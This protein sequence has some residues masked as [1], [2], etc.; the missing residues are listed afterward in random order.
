MEEYILSFDIP[1]DNIMFMQIFDCLRNLFNVLFYLFLHHTVILILAHVLEQI[2]AEAG[3]EKEIDVVLINK[4]LIDVYDVW[5][6]EKAL[7]FDLSNKL[8]KTILIQEGSIDHLQ[9]I[10]EI[11]SLVPI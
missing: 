9:A 1:V 11:G 3:L 8:I 5:V 6:V 10:D 4:E 7:Y 2:S